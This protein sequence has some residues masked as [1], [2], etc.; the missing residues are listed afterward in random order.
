M[1]SSGAVAGQR[2][3]EKDEHDDGEEAVGGGGRRSCGRYAPPRRTVSADKET[4]ETVRITSF[5]PTL[6]GVALSAASPGPCRHRRSRVRHRGAALADRRDAGDRDAGARRE[7]VGHRLGLGH[8]LLAG[9]GLRLGGIVDAERHAVEGVAPAARPS[10]MASPILSRS[11][12]VDGDAVRQR[13]AGQL[14]GI[15]VVRVVVDGLRLRPLVCRSASAIR[16][17]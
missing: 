11:R 9:L 7:R 13:V 4:T 14:R 16:A 2:D 6:T 8:R 12:I 10:S 17:S 1:P 15:A 3:Q 5:V